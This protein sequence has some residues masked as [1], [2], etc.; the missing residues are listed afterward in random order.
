MILW[1]VGITG[2]FSARFRMPF[3][4]VTPAVVV[5]ANLFIFGRGGWGKME[6]G[7]RQALICFNIYYSILSHLQLLALHMRQM[8]T[9]NGGG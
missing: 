7:W 9:D 4:K 1:A 2:G 3:T 8:M 5:W 6:E